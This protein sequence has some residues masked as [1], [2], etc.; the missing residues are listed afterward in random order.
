MVS[1]II[2]IERANVCQQLHEISYWGTW[3]AEPHPLPVIDP[4]GS[5]TAASF[6]WRVSSE[7]RKETER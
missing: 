1:S 7:T 2:F 6:L 3:L 5:Q 4:G